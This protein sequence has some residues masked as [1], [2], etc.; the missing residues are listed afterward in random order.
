[1]K[2]SVEVPYS[3]DK[4][5]MKRVKKDDFVKAHKHLADIINLPAEWDK[6]NKK[7]PKPE[8]EEK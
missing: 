4:D 8:K 1:M 3:F 7:E 6:A 5:Y 2:K